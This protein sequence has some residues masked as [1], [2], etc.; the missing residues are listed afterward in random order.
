MV[1]VGCRVAAAPAEG[2]GTGRVPGLEADMG[3]DIGVAV[4]LM[5][6]GGLWGPGR[7]R[8]L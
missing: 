7:G 2:I 4:G 8:R 3:V 6:A 1:R 5:G